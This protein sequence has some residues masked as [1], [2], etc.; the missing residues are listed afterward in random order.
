LRTD[1]EDYTKQDFRENDNF[2]AY[3]VGNSHNTLNSGDLKV[4]IAYLN[5]RNNRDSVDKNY[6][7]MLKDY[8]RNNSQ[9]TDKEWVR[10][11]KGTEWEKWGK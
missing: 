2:F 3:L 7:K 6:E 4:V 1:G 10:N 11:A 8:F 5:E 9:S